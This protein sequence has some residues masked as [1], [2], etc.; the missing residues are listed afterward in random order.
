MVENFRQTAPHGMYSFVSGSG[1]LP[2][3]LGLLSCCEVDQSFLLV[4]GNPT[5]QMGWIICSFTCG[6]PSV[7]I[8]VQ[9]FVGTYVFIF[10]RIF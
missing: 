8:C 4:C 3:D 9:V 2:H 7:N 5:M 6:Q 10:H 1:S